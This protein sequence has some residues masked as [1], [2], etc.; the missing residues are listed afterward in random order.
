MDPTD[1]EEQ[2]LV[3]ELQLPKVVGMEEKKR[4]LV[5]IKKNQAAQKEPAKGAAVEGQPPKERES[6]KEATTRGQLPTTEA[7]TA[8]RAKAGPIKIKLWPRGSQKNKK[9]SQ[10]RARG[11]K[12][13][14]MT[15][16]KEVATK[17]QVNGSTKRTGASGKCHD[18][19]FTLWE[20]LYILNTLHFVCCRRRDNHWKIRSCR[21]P[22]LVTPEL[23]RVVGNVVGLSN[24]PSTFMRF[25]NH[26]L[27]SFIRKFVVVYFNNIHIYSTSSEQHVE[28]LQ[29]VLNTL[30]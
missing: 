10:P 13:P 19:S 18:P 9:A 6:T 30:Q 21:R 24:A 22:L 5:E 1:F 16:T 2:Q 14:E 4:L 20:M 3:T 27:K 29:Q 26:V 11:K 23:R 25:I 12:A 17:D 7:M 28:H 15:V 8:E